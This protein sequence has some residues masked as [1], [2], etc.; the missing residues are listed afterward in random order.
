MLIQNWTWRCLNREAACRN[1]KKCYN[2]AYVQCKNGRFYGLFQ[3]RAAR[4][5]YWMRTDRSVPF[6]SGSQNV[7]SFPGRGLCR[8]PR[9]K[10][11]GTMLFSDRLLRQT[12]GL[13]Q[14]PAYSL[15]DSLLV[16]HRGMNSPSL[17]DSSLSNDFL[18]NVPPILHVPISLAVKNKTSLW[19]VWPNS[20][21]EYLLLVQK[22]TKYACG[23]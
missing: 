8:I 20:T 18:L 15:S 6:Q 11:A 1:R 17:I 19:N 21:M 4:V 14:I 9:H 16:S 3:G 23:F 2:S 7:R 10:T 12:A 13:C 22:P 5:A